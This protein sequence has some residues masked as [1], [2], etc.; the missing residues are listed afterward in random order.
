M[1]PAPLPGV[2]DSVAVLSP[3]STKV[4]PDGRALVSLIDGVGL[5]VV[6]TVKVPALPSVKAVASA[7]VIAGCVL[8]R[9]R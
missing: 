1:P 6:V 3:L 9:C 7:L 2:P 5:P 4:T 8:G